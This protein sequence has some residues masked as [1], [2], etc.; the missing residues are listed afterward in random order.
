MYKYEKGINQEKIQG[1]N[2]TLIL[3]LLRKEGLCS[4]V[5]LA[6]LTGLKQATVTNIM[7]DFIEW[8]L[9]KEVG[10]LNGSKGR[11]S[12]GIAL[13]T[14]RYRVIGVRL[15]RNYYS[16]SLFDLTG[17]EKMTVR[18]D[19]HIKDKPESIL[20]SMIKT[21]ESII[22][23]KEHEQVLSIGVALPGPFIKN[24]NRIGLITGVENWK[25]IL[26]E[27]E[28][29]DYFKLPVFLEH[30]AN[31]GAYAHL[32]H[33]EEYYTNETFIYIAAGQGIGA[34]IVINGEIYKGAI[35][36]AGEIGHMTI[37]YEG[38]KCA[39]GNTGCLE[40]YSSSIVFTHK[41]NEK[42]KSETP[43]SFSE[44][45]KMVHEGNEIGINEYRL[46]CKYLGIGIINVINSFNPDI[47]IIGDEMVKVDR[48]LMYKTINETV[49][50]GLIPE[51][52]EALTIRLS[53]FEK[54]SILHGA[55]IIAINEVFLNPPKFI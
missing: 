38:P 41:V 43:L 32:W 23:K 55:G 46:A 15:A 42:L 29:V 52:W 39:C 35:G 9:V 33:L 7:K 10:F 25:N 6:N 50:A 45:V 20:K 51:V 37:N 26:I 48:E 31:A 13:N 14:D 2:R 36:T 1:M 5:H 24:K 3:S 54:D 8:G 21:I 19:T 11:R 30:D 18:M 49:K 47:L 17:D 12:I 53:D 16:V 27:K 40:Q 4:R 34:G 44:V 28:L 22:K